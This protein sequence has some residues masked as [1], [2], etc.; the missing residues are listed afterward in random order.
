MNQQLQVSLT[1]PIPNDSILISKVELE[2]LKKEQ[3]LG[4][5]WSMG[6]LE[7]RIGKKKN[8]IKDNVLYPSRF[9]KVLDIENGGFVYYPK[10]QGQTWSF[11]ASKMA[12]F[13]D[14]NFR[15]IFR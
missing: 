7:K 4:V 2:E 15:S 14:K 9:K 10:S 12:V 5:Y 6:D 8:W 13:L 11:H 3:L 1:I